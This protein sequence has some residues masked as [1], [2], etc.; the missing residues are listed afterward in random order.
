MQSIR[1]LAKDSIATQLIKIVFGLYCVVA[2]LVTV[3]QVVVEYTHT[4]TQIRNELAINQQ[5]FEPILSAGLWNLDDE[6]IQNTIN[7]MLAIPI[8]TGVKIAQN[9]QLYNATG[10]VINDSGEQTT[11][12][13]RGKILATELISEQKLFSF[14]FKVHYD[15]RGQ[16]R[17]VGH[18]TLYSDPSAVISRL[19]MGVILLI[20]NS[21]IKTLAL[22]ILFFYVGKRVLVKPLHKLTHTIEKV[23]FENLDNFKLD[24]DLDSKRRNELTRIQQAF[25]QMVKKLAQA[26]TSIVDLNNNLESTVEKRTLALKLAKEDAELANQAKSIF[27]SRVNHELRT[28]LN[29][30]IGCSQ[31]LQQKL[32]TPQDRKMTDHVIEAAEH[33][34]MLFED[35]MDVVILSGEEVT[36]SLSECDID[37]IV[38]SCVA[39]VK[40][41]AQ[42]HNV[43]IMAHDC[44]HKVY[45]N[46]GR[47]KQILLNLLTNAIKYNSPNGNVEI[48]VN[49][50]PQDDNIKIS[51][52]DSGV[53]IN[54]QDLE[55]IF[56][57]MTRLAYAEEH[58]IDGTGIGL[59]IVDNLVK[60][61]DGQIKVSSVL[62]QGSEFI[63]TLPA[64]KK[65]NHPD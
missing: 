48:T 1:F 64:T 38:T 35:I 8:I 16:R 24:L 57:P 17:E 28:P 63:I 36:I 50:Q 37:T 31:I 21:I 43:I 27:M 18:A 29:A 56:E 11:Y 23:D 14:D 22:W 39:M 15:F 62:G 53:G 19:Q 30:I 49:R 7:G 55:A 46:A 41:Q 59:S 12:D 65:S 52:K 13:P 47:L 5:I 51:V 40:P 61:M 20:V 60:K 45:A 4:K 54:P 3:T 44:G 58:C 2:V 32:E 42:Q 10:K 9:D 25:E 34:L 26:K 6:Q 33:L